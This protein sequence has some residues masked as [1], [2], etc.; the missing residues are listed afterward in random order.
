MSAKPA[1][2]TAASDLFIT[3]HGPVTE[4]AARP[5]PLLT[6]DAA[7]AFRRPASE[8][9][10]QQRPALLLPLPVPTAG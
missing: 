4:G 10:K 9:L 7:V 8:Y 3:L 1:A 5:Y 6:P 2:A